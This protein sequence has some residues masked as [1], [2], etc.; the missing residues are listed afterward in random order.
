MLIFDVNML[1]SAGLCC[2]PEML[3]YYL[4]VSVCWWFIFT[5]VSMHCVLV[6]FVLVY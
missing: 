6:L 3:I 1:G 5:R 2:Y 4:W